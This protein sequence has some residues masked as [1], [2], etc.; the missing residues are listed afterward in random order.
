MLI[1]IHFKFFKYM[2]H[3]AERD[4]KNS[5]KGSATSITEKKNIC[6]SGGNSLEK[7]KE[8]KYSAKLSH[9]GNFSN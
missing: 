8:Y 9:K 1:K 7:N 2:L 5:P 6:I 3:S 4:Y